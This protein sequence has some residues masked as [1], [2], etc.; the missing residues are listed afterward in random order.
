MT[1][2]LRLR[3]SGGESLPIAPPS[4]NPTFTYQAVGLKSNP[5][6]ASA[7]VANI[8]FGHHSNGQSGCAFVEQERDDEDECVPRD[9][10]S[11]INVDDGNFS[12]HYL[13]VSLHKSW[14]KPKER[15]GKTL[16]EYRVGG[17]LEVHSWCFIPGDLCELADDYG[18]ARWWVSAG[19][20]ELGGETGRW[21]VRGALQHM[22]GGRD[23]QAPM[24]L[25][26]EIFK[27]FGQ[28]A[29]FWHILKGVWWARLLQYQF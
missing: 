24:A 26:F 21:V 1:M 13:R 23:I 20:M 25:S 11:T 22:F 6:Q 17:G 5:D 3:M 4:F 15:W 10:N 12:T 27:Y 28:A 8:T 16:T 14:T 19:L 7:V 9:G 29:G 2:L 18:R